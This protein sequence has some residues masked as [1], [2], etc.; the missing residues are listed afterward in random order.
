MSMRTQTILIVD[1]DR[2]S[3]S[4][5]SALFAETYQIAQ[6]DSISQACALMQQMPV[7]LMLIDMTD[8]ETDYDIFFR[9]RLESE[10]LSHIPIYVLTDVLDEPCL[11]KLA[12]YD[13]V[14]HMQKPILPQVLQL[15]IRNLLRRMDPAQLNLPMLEDADSTHQNPHDCNTTDTLTGLYQRNYFCKEAEER[16]AKAP[17]EHYVIACMDVDHFKLINDQYGL[18]FGDQ[19]LQGL[20]YVIRFYLRQCGGIAS[21]IFAD[22]FA[23]MLPQEQIPLLSEMMKAMEQMML[24]HGA[25]LRLHISCGCCVAAPL[26]DASTILDRAILAKRSVKGLYDQHISYYDEKMRAQLLQEQWVLGEMEQALDS[27]QFVLWLQPQYDVATR[28]IIGAE[29]LVRWN[30]PERGLIMPSIF[31]DLFERNGFIYHL[32]RYIW[33]E[34]CKLLKQWMSDGKQPLPISVNVSRYD[35]FQPDFYRVITGLVERYN[36]PKYLFRVEITES[37]FTESTEELFAIIEQLQNYG[38]VVEIDD[39]GSGYSSFN[40]LKDVT[41]DVLKIDMRFLSNSN[42][43]ARSGN[44]LESIVRMAKWLDMRVIAEGVET[45][46]QATFLRSIGCPYVQGFYFS[47]PMPVQ[48]Y[49]SLCEDSPQAQT[50]PTLTAVPGMNPDSFWSPNSLETL[51]FN[52]YAGGACVFELLNGQT[53]LL[54]VNEKYAQTFGVPWSELQMLRQNA[55]FPFPLQNRYLADQAINAAIETGNPQTFE[56]ECDFTAFTGKKEWIRFTLSMIAHTGDRYL[57]YQY[58]ENITAQRKAETEM[59]EAFEQIQFLSDISNQLLTTV[60]SSDSIRNVLKRILDYF[61]AS[62]VYILEPDAARTTLS[63]TYEIC[64]E[65][66]KPM[67]DS[68]TPTPID[69]NLYWM[70]HSMQHSESMQSGI[71]TNNP[72]LSTIAIRH[73]NALIGLLCVE[74]P[75]YNLEQIPHMV[76]LGDYISVTFARRNLNERLRLEHEKIES[77]MNGMPGGYVQLQQNDTGD[78][79]ILFMNDGLFHLL[80]RVPK[81]LDEKGMDYLFSYLHPDDVSLTQDTIQKLDEAHPKEVIHVRLRRSDDI[82]I[83]VSAH[84]VL[85]P[86]PKNSKTMFNVYLSDIS[87]I[88]AVDRMRLELLDY[89]PCGACMYE[90]VNGEFLILY[91]NPCFVSMVN[92]DPSLFMGKQFIETLHPDD[93]MAIMKHIG[94]TIKTKKSVTMPVRILVGEH[95]DYRHF[96]MTGRIVQQEQDRLI[97]FAYFTALDT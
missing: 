73:R 42:Q 94:E 78:W 51:V 16:I 81:S 70:R 41:A 71:E 37:A 77:I 40:T 33:E 45:Q 47:K 92:R 10:A 62:R 68:Y 64:D 46:E 95:D 27:G 34:T 55:T 5:I 28:A 97:A 6:A 90:I 54:R 9:Q 50:A 63:M 36:I 2:D 29:A 21:R 38:L 13:I 60:Y 82:Y 12:E 89:L 23:V 57:F 84:L 59:Y 87:A 8:S 15:E 85:Q 83:D 75:A 44:I 88:M 58:V 4:R 18:V 14:G 48:E 76:P 52:R 3:L 80:K 67:I 30:H 25:P 74:Q 96:E 66:V 53:E 56:A 86:T 39:F 69:A 91:R 26:L 61:G 31:I 20:A 93:R 43:S 49:E 1:S 11:Q 24:G 32:D 22:N 65:Q 35:V 17:D 7:N 79:H 72:L 19:V